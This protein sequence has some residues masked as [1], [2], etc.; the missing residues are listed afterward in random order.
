MSPDDNSLRGITLPLFFSFLLGTTV[1]AVRG[2]WQFEQAWERV[3]RDRQLISGDPGSYLCAMGDVPIYAGI[4]G[5]M[6][7]GVAGLCGGFCWLK[8]RK[9]SLAV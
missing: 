7:G 2:Q 3:N 5:G 1:G 9:D 4:A 6:L 8:L